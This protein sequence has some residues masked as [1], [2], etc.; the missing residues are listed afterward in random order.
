M[1][2]EL[3]FEQTMKIEKMKSNNFC[4]VNT[5]IFFISVHDSFKHLR[6]TKV[7]IV[8]KTFTF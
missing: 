8:N 5:V 6:R 1:W 4:K 2:Y 3:W 7:K